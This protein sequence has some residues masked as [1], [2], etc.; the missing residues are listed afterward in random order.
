MAERNND[1][2]GGARPGR[3]K[4]IDQFRGFAIISM[5]IINY[6]ALFNATP[7]WLKHAPE[8]G[9]TFA[10]LVAPY[11]VFIIGLMY[12]RPSTS[13]PRPWHAP[14]ANGMPQ[15]G[16]LPCSTG[17]SCRPSARPASSRSRLSG[18]LLPCAFSEASCFWR[19]MNSCWDTRG[20]P[21]S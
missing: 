7:A 17:E 15:S 21:S 2:A 9:L 16:H 14:L 4:S 8:A 10:D 1:T 6:L 3:I 5:I 12:G 11:F 19:H 20:T 18:S 13:L